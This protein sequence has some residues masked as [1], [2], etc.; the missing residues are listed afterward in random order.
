VCVYGR[1]GVLGLSFSSVLR[2]SFYR[3]KEGGLHTWGTSEIISFPLDQ[4]RTVDSPCCQTLRGMALGMIIAL[5]RL[6][7][8]PRA[9]PCA[10][11]P[12]DVVA[13]AVEVRSAPCLTRRGAEGAADGGLAPA[14]S[15]IASESRRTC[16]PRVLQRRKYKG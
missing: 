9:C 11:A 16:L 8:M 3:L 10:V 13:M 14:K 7:T 2:P 1:L 15:R 5:G 4:G 6:L 12:V